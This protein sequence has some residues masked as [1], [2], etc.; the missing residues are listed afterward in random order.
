MMSQPSDQAFALIAACQ[1][2]H[3]YDGLCPECVDDAISAA[4][5][6]TWEEAAKHIEGDSCA[7]TCDHPTCTMLNTFAAQLRERAR[8][9]EGPASPRPDAVQA[10][11]QPMTSHA[12]EAEHEIRVAI[13]EALMGIRNTNGKPLGL[14]IRGEIESALLP[15]AR[16]F[17]AAERRRLIALAREY[18]TEST[19]AL[20]DH[21]EQEDP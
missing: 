3:F 6:E 9:L 11:P 17:I 19:S 12:R 10:E 1:A 20:A 16:A 21:L 15:V 2:A 5:R 4:R 14:H 7:G 13:A 18:G 8:G